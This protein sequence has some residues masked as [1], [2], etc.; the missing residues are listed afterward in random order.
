MIHIFKVIGKILKLNS[1]SDYL[2]EIVYL[3]TII[4]FIYFMLYYLD[5]YIS[6]FYI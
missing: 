4:Y 2:N 5:F 3:F 1:L 6:Y